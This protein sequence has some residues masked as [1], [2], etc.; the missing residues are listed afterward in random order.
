MTMAAPTVSVVA[1]ARNEE[2]NLAELHERV[3]AAMEASGETWELIIV[4]DHSTDGTFDCLRSLAARDSRV[5]GIRLSRHFGSHAARACGLH[6]AAGECA[7]SIAADLQDPPEKIPQLLSEWRG[8]AQ[9]VSSVRTS[10]DG[11][12]MAT[13]F[14]SWLYQF[15]MRH[16]AGLDGENVVSSFC[17]LDRR[18]IDSL[19]Q[20]PETNTSGLALLAS[21]G[22]R[23]AAVTYDQQP[24]RRGKSNWTLPMKVKLFTDSLTAHSALPIRLFACAGLGIALTGFG[25][26]LHAAW[27]LATGGGKFE[28]LVLLGA[29]LFLGGLQLVMIGVVGEYIWRTLAD[30]RRRP[31][32]LVE[33][34]TGPR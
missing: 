30:A 7:V 29:M 32:Y 26:F 34:T 16:A 10:R 6:H 2:E 14:F 33:E 17:L 5:R 22:F 4:D 18:A 8:G 23:R 19:G 31:Q 11:E 25:V 21:M 15:T 3:A 27:R 9:I 13:R 1:C 24:R 20:F 12:T 28:W